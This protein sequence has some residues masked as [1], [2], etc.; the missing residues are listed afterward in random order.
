VNGGGYQ[1]DIEQTLNDS[2]DIT[3][4]IKVDPNHVGQVADI[5]VIAETTLP[6]T[7]DVLYFMLDEGLRA[8]LLWDENPANLAAFMPNVVLQS[9]Q[10]VP[11]YQGYFIYSGTLKVQ[12]GYRLQD[13]T[14]V[15]NER[16]IAINIRE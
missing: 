8:I 1:T 7:D 4:Q 14:V 11:M 16:G 9:I 10:T 6:F 12:F 15:M 13:G 2:V 5:F 3:G